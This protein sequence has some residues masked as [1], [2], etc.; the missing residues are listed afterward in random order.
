MK[1]PVV[2]LIRLRGSALEGGL[3]E[4]LSKFI[5]GSVGVGK[6]DNLL[7]DSGGADVVEK[8]VDEKVGL[9]GAG[10][11]AHIDDLGVAQNGVLLLVI[12]PFQFI[13]TGAADELHRGRIREDLG[14]Q[15]DE[16]HDHAV[17]DYIGL[18]VYGRVMVHHVVELVLQGECCLGHLVVLVPLVELLQGFGEGAIAASDLIVELVGDGTHGFSLI[19]PITIRFQIVVFEQA[20]KLLY[21]FVSHCLIPKMFAK[22]RFASRLYLCSVNPADYD[23]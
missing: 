7:R 2:E 3:A 13:G 22:F 19:G 17:V 9:P 11:G 5:G 1:R 6:G 10:T 15:V 23:L 21:P 8:L 4:A 16:A 12:E 14:G 20:V 18:L